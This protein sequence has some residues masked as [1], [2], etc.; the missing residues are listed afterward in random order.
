MNAPVT[1]LPLPRA[2]QLTQPFWQ[3]AH[4]HRLVVQRCKACGK[5]RFYPS[6]GCEHCGSMDYEWVQCSGRGRIY[7]WIV[8]HRNVDP[9]WQ[10]RTPF[11]SAI[12]ELADQA[13][14]L[15]PGLLSEIAPDKVVANLE[16]EVWFE[17]MTPD[18]SLPRWRPIA[19][20]A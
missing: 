3:A 2:N 10:K 7:S 4:E 16:V 12:V 19:R 9:G 20:R 8:V 5:M 11:V 1:D 18:I 13:H 17:D 15:V 14:V 6:G